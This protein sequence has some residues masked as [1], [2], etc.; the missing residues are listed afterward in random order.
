MGTQLPL[1]QRGTEAPEFNFVQC[2]LW[3]SGCPSQEL[4]SSC[5][6]GLPKPTYTIVTRWANIVL[7]YD[8]GPICLGLQNNREVLSPSICNGALVHFCIRSSFRIPMDTVH[9]QMVGLSRVSRVSRVSVRI[10]VSVRFSFS[11]SKVQETDAMAF[12]NIC[13]PKDKHGWEHYRRQS[14]HCGVITV[15]LHRFI[16][17]V[18]ITGSSIVTS[19]Q[20]SIGKWKIRPHL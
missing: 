14:V 5:T 4:L 8:P 19:I 20:K 1:T 15:C 16:N 10:R 6:N 11:G 9:R 2:L 17:V 7:T 13:C 18:R 3:P 12:P